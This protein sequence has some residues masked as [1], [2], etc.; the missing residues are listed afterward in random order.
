MSLGT[1]S[2]QEQSLRLSVDGPYYC[3]AALVCC[4]M[5]ALHGMA[6]DGSGTCVSG[7]SETILS[8][9]GTS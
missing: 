5:V 8:G 1:L 3:L 2:M 7:I 9:S 4:F 6:Q